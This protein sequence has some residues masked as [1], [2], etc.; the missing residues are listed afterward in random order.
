MK[1]E[2]CS[3]R[4]GLSLFDTKKEKGKIEEVRTLYPRKCWEGMKRVGEGEIAHDYH[5]VHAK[6]EWY[7]CVV[8]EEYKEWKGEERLPTVAREVQERVKE[9]IREFL[10]THDV[11]KEALASLEENW[12]SF[13]TN[14]VISTDLEVLKQKRTS[15]GGS[16]KERENRGRN[17]K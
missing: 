11:E 15:E 8:P 10:T 5:N 7:G 16:A 4:A 12:N 14:K 6:P 3:L 2:L 1:G 17:N 13:E 9:G